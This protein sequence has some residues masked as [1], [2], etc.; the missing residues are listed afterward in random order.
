M[1]FSEAGRLHWLSESLTGE[2]KTMALHPAVIA[3]VANL[4]RSLL[5]HSILDCLT[6]S[7]AYHERARYRVR[8]E[9]LSRPFFNE[10]DVPLARDSLRAKAKA[11]WRTFQMMPFPGETITPSSPLDQGDHEEILN[12]LP[13][14]AGGKESLQAFLENQITNTWTA[15]EVLY[16]RLCE[17]ARAAFPQMFLTLDPGKTLRFASLAAAQDSYKKAFGAGSP[18]LK[19]LE[20]PPFEI[21]A[22]VRNVLEHN[23]GVC[24]ADYLKRAT[25]YPQLLPQGN[26]GNKL[27]LD[28]NITRDIIQPAI[29]IVAPLIRKV[30]AWIQVRIP[31]P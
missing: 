29:S 27:Q 1:N 16:R 9:G 21:L 30:D 3:V 2:I 19:L 5:M 24:D 28:G 12:S 25:K 18:P 26:L 10:G 20:A 31:P 8:M 7:T 14:Y 4:R 11:E 6:H 15:M 23:A 13:R 17:D 22:S